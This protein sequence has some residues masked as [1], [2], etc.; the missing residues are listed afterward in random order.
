MMFLALVRRKAPVERSSRTAWILAK[1][2]S[3]KGVSFPDRTSN[4]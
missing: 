2:A 3:R 4:F 1:S